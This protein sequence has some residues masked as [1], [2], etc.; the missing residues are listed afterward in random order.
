[1]FIWSRRVAPARV[2]CRYGRV[3]GL[4]VGVVVCACVSAHAGRLFGV[5]AAAVI[6]VVYGCC[7]SSGS[8]SGGSCD[9]AEFI[10]EAGATV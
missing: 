6:E 10:N 1:M 9:A 8:S 4:L 5:P 3:V 7:S 2:L